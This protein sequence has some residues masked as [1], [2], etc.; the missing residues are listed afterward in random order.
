MT[1]AT[2]NTDLRAEVDQ[3]ISAGFRGYG[4]GIAD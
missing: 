1:L 2:Q 4:K 3:L